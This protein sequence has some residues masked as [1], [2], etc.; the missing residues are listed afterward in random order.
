MSGYKTLLLENI[1]EKAEENLRKQGV[2]VDME[3]K[4]LSEEEL[5]KIVNERGINILGIRSKTSVSSKIINNCPSLLAIGAFCIGTNQIDLDSCQKQGVAVFNAPYSNGRS[6]VE[7]AVCLIIA[8]NRRLVE[9][10]NLAKEGVWNKTSHHSYEVRGKK[11]GIIGYGN[12]GSQLSVIAESLGID[13]YYY[14]LIERPS[15]GNAT[16]CESLEKMLAQMDIVS[17]HIDGRED[18]HSF[19]DSQKFSLMKDGS[20]FIN[21]ARGNVVEVDSLAA[22]LENGKL[23]GAAVD[24]FPSEPKSNRDKFE[25]VLQKYPNVI[26]TPH[27]GGSTQEAQ[28]NIADFVPMQII[29]Y[30]KNGDTTMSVNF[31]RINLPPISGLNRFIHI[32]KNTPGI[33]AKINSILASHGINIEGQ[34]LKTNEAI[35]YVIT[36]TNTNIS[37]ELVQ[38]IEGVENTVTTRVL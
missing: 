20:Y 26:L 21:L 10:H 8:L 22:S 15:L 4:S 17:L 3:E 29:N 9:N 27:I 36:D 16:K 19:F 14:D 37:S 2:L 24:V 6:V 28:Q 34:Y 12:I 7:L 25:S 1:H 35:G 38:E 23:A 13:V 33:L 32:H 18:N 11:L 31:P 5:I 30:I